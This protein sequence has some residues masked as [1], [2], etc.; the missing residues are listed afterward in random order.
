[1]GV[2]KLFFG[3]PTISEFYA[4]LNELKSLGVELIELGKDV[5][6]REIYALKIGQGRIRIAIV[7]TQHGSEPAPALATV[8]FIYKLFKDELRPRLSRKEILERVK[9]LAIPVA[10]P[11]GFEKVRTCL[12][13]CGAPS[14]VCSCTEARFVIADT[15]M[16]R[17]WLELRTLNTKLIHRCVRDFE[18]HLILDLHEF[19]ARGGAP[20]KWAHETEGFDAYVTDTPYIGVSPEVA[21]ISMCVAQSVKASIESSTGLVT[22]LLRPSDG[23]SVQPPIYLGTHFPLEG[24]AKVLVETWGTGLGSYLLFERIVAHIEA[25]TTSI[26]ILIDMERELEALVR[27]DRLYDRAV[28][29]SNAARFVIKGNELGRAKALLVEHGIE[30]VESANA[31]MVDVPQRK[32]NRMALLL[33]DKEFYINRALASRGR[34]YTLDRITDVVIEKKFKPSE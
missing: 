28:G 31:V 18:P 9:I 23:L 8:L 2:E 16:N 32:F 14:W 27:G 24:I 30:F 33:L 7:A 3:I 11:S 6:G 25:I 1:M 34:L 17:D 20:P 21:F 10:N 15:D 26:E 29:E 22:K 19:Y 13:S 5:E 12:E 4:T